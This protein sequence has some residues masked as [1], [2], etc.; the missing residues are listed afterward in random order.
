[1]KKIVKRLGIVLLCLLLLALLVVG[2]YVIYL[3]SLY[4]RIEDETALTPQ[5]NVEATLQANGTYSALTYNI[6]FGAY[7]PEFTFFMDTGI[8]TDGTFVQGTQSRA[9]SE[10]HASANTQG[11][12]ALM[13]SL[14]PDFLLLQEVDTQ[15]HRSHFIDQSAAVTDAFDG[16]VSVFS[17][18]FHSAYL[19]YPPTNPHG[20]VQSGLLTLGRYHMSSALRR[21]YPINETFPAKFFDLDRCFVIHRF[22]VD[23][24]GELVLINSHM[25]AYDEGGTSRRAQLTLLQ[26]ILSQEYEKGNWV[27]VGGDFN[28]ALGGTIEAFA[29]QQ[30]IPDWVSVLEDAS[31]LPEGF[32]TVVADNMTQVATVRSSDLPYTPGVN[33]LT[34]VDGF[35]VSANVQA[36]AHNVDAAFAYSD[37][38]PVLLTFTLTK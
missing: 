25:S 18:N 29:S 22:P 11:S 2:G 36:T 16:Y 23:G 35:I 13:Q 31:D 17:S 9:S 10:A 19:A 26:S 21:S 27:I 3:Q 34:V 37:H 8:M 32:S 38:N 5:N 1:M 14:S 24:G 20:K 7:D 28:H 6:G 30:Q 33:Y 12:V 4:Y 15:S